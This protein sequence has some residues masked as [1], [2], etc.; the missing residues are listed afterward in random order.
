MDIIRCD[1]MRCTVLELH[2][3]KQCGTFKGRYSSFIASLS[4]TT[5][6]LELR[7]WFQEDLIIVNTMIIIYLG[8]EV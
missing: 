1:Q 8:S 5:A 4:E 7:G 2:I 3:A 6:S